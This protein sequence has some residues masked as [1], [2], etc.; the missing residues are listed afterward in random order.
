M[1]KYNCAN[2]HHNSKMEKN[3]RK[4][5]GELQCKIVPKCK[6]SY[7]LQVYTNFEILVYENLKKYQNA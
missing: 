4:R 2:R 5:K 6:K 1:K 7:N 3:L